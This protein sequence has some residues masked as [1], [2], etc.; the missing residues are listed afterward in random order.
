M[1]HPADGRGLL[2]FFDPASIK[3]AAAG[4]P[5]GILNQ[6]VLFHEGLHGYTGHPDFDLLA[7]FQY[8]PP[9]DPSCDITFYLE[10]TIWNQ[11]LPTCQ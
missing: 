2:T 11:S 3:L 5:M 6:A 1:G 9:F 8:N 7:D 4:T 10:T